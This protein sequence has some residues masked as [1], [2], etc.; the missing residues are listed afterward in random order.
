MA[1]D[2]RRVEDVILL[3]FHG[4]LTYTSGIELKHRVA[5][6]ADGDTAK[7]ILNLEDVTYVDSS[8]LGAIVDTFIKLRKR[9]GDLRFVNPSSRCRHLLDI[10]NI[11]PAVQT[12]PSEN[13]ALASFG[14]GAG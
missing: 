13:D 5:Q 14:S 3:N 9:G 7:V 11:A 10:T 8:G 2:E 6:L 12:F 4:Q 1:F